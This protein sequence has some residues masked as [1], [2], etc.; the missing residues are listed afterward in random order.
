MAHFDSENVRLPYDPAEGFVHALQEQRE[1]LDALQTA[2][3]ASVQYDVTTQPTRRWFGRS[4]PLVHDGA[5][6]FD[7]DFDALGGRPGADVAR[8]MRGGLL[9]ASDTAPKDPR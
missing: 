4:E 6:R 1:R 7:P 8:S 9:L 2:C 5:K 3:T